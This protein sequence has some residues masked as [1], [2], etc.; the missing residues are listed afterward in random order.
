MAKLEIIAEKTDV[1][2]KE[3]LEEKEPES[4]LK[5]ISAF[6][7]TQGG[8][9]YFGVRDDREIIG[10]DDP[11]DVVEK[12][13]DFIK[14][15]IE[16]IPNFRID[17]K[18]EKG[19][20]IVIVEV[21]KGRNTPYYYS[22]RGVKTAYVRIG[23]SSVKS[24]DYMLN[25]LILSGKGSSY[26]AEVTDK[27]LKDYSFTLLKITYKNRTGEEFQD[28]YFT[29]FGLADSNGY[30]TN[31][32]LLLA[33]ECPVLQSRIFC[34]RWRG[35]EMTI[36]DENRD[37]IDD[38]EFNGNLIQLLKDGQNFL[39]LHN[40]K[41][42]RKSPNGR[43]EKIEYDEKS[44]YEAL[45][46][47]LIHR[48]YSIVGSE[49]HID[50]FDNRI[51]IYSPGGMYDGTKIQEQDLMNIK[52]KRRN[53]MIADVFSRL[54]LMERKHSGIKDIYKRLGKEHKVKFYS[55]H[56]DFTVTFYNLYYNGTDDGTEVGTDNDTEKMNTIFNEIKNKP[57]ITRKELNE[58]LNIPERTIARIIKQLKENGKIER[59]GTDR[60]GYWE[61]IE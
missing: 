28:S 36:Q 11:Q 58:K 4:W 46:N 15:R 27:L 24:P 3:A 55:D 47:A 37:I 8:I 25:E 56:D 10:L 41:F 60:K 16:P 48:V 32:G 2:F 7:N 13:S 50:I 12:I 22:R 44:L 19:S 59:R 49:V 18:N 9:L 14:T 43:I 45:T 21:D 29:S 5:D 61:I 52:S 51:E 26:D 57:N 40:R 6:A 34:T 17:A 54:I 39:K 33:D 23:S 31:A 38:K 20:E 35:L 1:D 53:P 30:I 42:W